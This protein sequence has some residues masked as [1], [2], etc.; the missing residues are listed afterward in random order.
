[1][2]LADGRDPAEAGCHIPLRLL[3][4]S[5]TIDVIYIVTCRVV[6]NCANEHFLMGGEKWREEEKKGNEVGGRGKEVIRLVYALLEFSS[7][8]LIILAI[9]LLSGALMRP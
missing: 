8:N 7:L 4:I 3:S 9:P 1:M 5:D 6:F 2:L